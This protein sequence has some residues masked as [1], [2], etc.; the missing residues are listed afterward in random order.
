MRTEEIKIYKFSEL[1]DEAK[2]RAIDNLRDIN[3]DHDW[4]DFA[5][6]DAE[7]VY[8]K[9]TGFDV[10]RGSYCN[11]EF[12][13]SPAD[14]AEAILANH[15]EVC[16]TYKLAKGF[17]ENLE[18]LTNDRDK[19]HDKAEEMYK[20][21]K[22]EAYDVCM[23]HAYDKEDEIENLEDEFL[24]ELSEEYLTMLREEYEY[25]YSDEAVIETIEANDYEFTEDGNI[26]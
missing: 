23:E 2:E 14:T 8:L 11:I 15:G 18:E 16:E 1:S 26:Y 17:L 10:G 12:I 19:W 13:D 24:K 6:M 9:I 4:W 21:D 5:Y 20:E 3:L 7:N 25:K 22:E